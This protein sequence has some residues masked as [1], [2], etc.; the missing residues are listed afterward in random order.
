M[1]LALA[2]MRR[3][4]VC[5]MAGL[6][7]LLRSSGLMQVISAALLISVE[8]AEE[9]EAVSALKFDREAVQQYLDT[10]GESRTAEAKLGPNE[11]HAMLELLPDATS[12]G[13]VILLV[14]LERRVQ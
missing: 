12:P 11:V 13:K 8:S 6:S 14:A 1:R 5:N 4:I 7:W 2:M 10:A 9:S 3:T